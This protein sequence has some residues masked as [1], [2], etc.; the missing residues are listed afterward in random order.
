[1]RTTSFEIRLLYD[2]S[3]TSNTSF[4][5][6]GKEWGKRKMEGGRERERGYKE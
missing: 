6:I 3:F 1:M 5:R 4:I 2:A